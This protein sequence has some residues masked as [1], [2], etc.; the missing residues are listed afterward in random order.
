M[1]RK[2][3]KTRCGGLPNASADR[4]II[5]GLFQMLRLSAE[6]CPGT[7]ERFE[8]PPQQGCD[9]FSKA[10]KS[11]CGS[12]QALEFA[13]SPVFVGTGPSPPLGFIRVKAEI[14]DFCG[15]TSLP[16]ADRVEIVSRCLLTGQ[17]QKTR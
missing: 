14:R 6:I 1:L 10:L 12:L 3:P 4:E 16:R 2:R 11:G 5:S 9:A 7:F 15:E 17:P 8:N 13:D